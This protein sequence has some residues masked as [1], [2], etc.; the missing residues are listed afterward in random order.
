MGGEVWGGGSGGHPGEGV[1]RAQTEGPGAPTSS[2]S[3]EGPVFA[4]LR[5]APIDALLPSTS[6][7]GAGRL[8]SVAALYGVLWRRWHL[9]VTT[10]ICQGINSNSHAISCF[11]K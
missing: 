4:A 9:L 6:C 1:S 10:D 2:P 8:E 5:P 3:F 7:A 11:M